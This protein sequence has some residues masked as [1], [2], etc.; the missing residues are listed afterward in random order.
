[1]SVADRR[2]SGV[3]AATDPGSPGSQRI[4]HRLGQARRSQGLSR[5]CLARKLATDASKIKIEERPTTDL[6][7]SRLY[8]WQ[9]ALEVPVTELL[10]EAGDD[11]AAPVLRRAQLVRVMKTAL[12]ILEA[13]REE[14]IRRMAQTLIDQFVAIMPE[15]QG[16]TAWHTVGKRRRRDEFGVAASRRMSEDVFIDLM[17]F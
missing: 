3:R 12:A 11:L 9:E 2:R 6:L 15:L 4:L 13:T 10:V 1:M 7:L 14:P 8:Q 5:R 17:D 16:I